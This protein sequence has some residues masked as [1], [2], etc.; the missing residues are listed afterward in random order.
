MLVAETVLKIQATNP[1]IRVALVLAILWSIATSTTAAHGSGNFLGLLGIREVPANEHRQA[2][3]REIYALP[4][5]R[6]SSDEVRG[7]SA[8][9]TLDSS[10]ESQ[11]A[12]LR[13]T[14]F[15]TFH[16]LLPFEWRVVADEPLAHVL[17]EFVD[18]S[19]TEEITFE[20]LLR[21]FNVE[22]IVAPTYEFKHPDVAYLNFEIRSLERAIY[23][24]L[25][26]H[27]DLTQSSYFI[28]NPAQVARELS[29]EMLRFEA[30][31]DQAGRV[32]PWMKIIKCMGAWSIKR[33][34]KKEGSVPIPVAYNLRFGSFS[35]DSGFQQLGE[36]DSNPRQ[37]PIDQPFLS[38]Y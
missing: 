27:L 18:Y 2:S 13:R 24:E 22:V 29:L 12:Y 38:T 17:P 3:I 7:F 11:T 20:D 37:F 26:M 21:I 14:G 28:T 10:N 34:D 33:G 9:V 1:F 36:T 6:S 19:S 31:S 23:V 8:T 25:P 16:E 15:E 35:M 5:L 30:L 32:K 4:S